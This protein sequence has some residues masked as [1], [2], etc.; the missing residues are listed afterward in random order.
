VAETFS[1]P[2][3]AERFPTLRD[4]IVERRAALYT[5]QGGVF[6]PEFLPEGT[7]FIE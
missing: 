1:L 5:E 6:P 4:A 2:S 7:G 3:L